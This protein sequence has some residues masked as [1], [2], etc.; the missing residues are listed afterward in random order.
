M[1]AVQRSGLQQGSGRCSSLHIG[2]QS[3]GQDCRM[4]R[5]GPSQESR[6]LGSRDPPHMEGLGWLWPAGSSPSRTR[7]QAVV[8]VLVLL[9]WELVL[10]LELTASSFARAS[11]SEFSSPPLGSPPCPPPGWAETCATPTTCS[12]HSTDHTAV[13]WALG[14]LRHPLS[15]PGSCPELSTGEVCTWRPGEQI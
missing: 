12:L 11:P 2:S 8:L 6:K 9:P 10:H 7:P 1:T 5:V 4:H 3:A 13:T 14:P 15:T